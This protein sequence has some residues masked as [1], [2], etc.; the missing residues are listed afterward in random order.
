VTYSGPLSPHTLM[1]RRPST[2]V[3]QCNA[4][5]YPV[6]STQYTLS[7]FCVTVGRA[8][9]SYHKQVGHAPALAYKQTRTRPVSFS[10]SCQHLYGP[11]LLMRIITF[12]P[13]LVR[14]RKSME[15]I[16]IPTIERTD[17]YTC[18]SRASRFHVL[19]RDTGSGRPFP[20][21]A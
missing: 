5:L 4:P 16:Q 13:E 21:S 12:F 19:G 1:G 3:L 6:P 15:I 10:S 2:L 8:S 11:D 7:Q 20:H 17:A 14:G 18:I 9:R